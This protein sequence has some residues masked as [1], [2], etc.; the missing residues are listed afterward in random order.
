MVL[1]KID[2]MTFEVFGDKIN[3]ARNLHKLFFPNVI[4]PVEWSI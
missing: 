4:V 3:F 1:P 2:G